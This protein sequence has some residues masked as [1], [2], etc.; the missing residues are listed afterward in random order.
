MQLDFVKTVNSE[1]TE[2]S[3]RLGNE[4]ILAKSF[5]SKEEAKS[6]SQKKCHILKTF[7][8]NEIDRFKEHCEL[9]AV[10]G[11]NAEANA[12][13]A[14]NKK[15]DLLLMPAGNERNEFDFATARV[16]KNNGLKIGIL[17]S[18]FLNSENDKKNRLFRNYLTVAKFC[19]KLELP[20]IVF[21]GAGKAADLRCIED[22]SAFSEMLGIEGNKARNWQKNSAEILLKKKKQVIVIEG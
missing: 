19:N 20:M 3:G 17:F 16:A 6:V 5:A 14:N 13:A 15:V 4:I 1:I 21:S 18:E 10:L 8:G 11:G 12:F 9:I 2:L 22:L 7:N